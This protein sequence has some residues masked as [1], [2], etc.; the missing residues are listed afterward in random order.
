MTDIAGDLVRLAGTLLDFG[1]VE[2]AT[3]HQDGKTMETDTTHTVMLAVVACCLAE[4]YAPEL[5][6]GAIAQLALVH[7][8]PEVYAGDTQTL[9][10]LT[11]QAQQD[12]ERRELA[13]EDQL[14]REYQM[15]LWLVA[16]LRSY[17]DQSSK[18][19]RWVRAV[20][21]LLPKLTHLLNDVCV[22]LSKGMT[23]A[24][25]DLRYRRQFSEMVYAH[26]WPELMDLYENLA[27]R[28]LARAAEKEAG[29]ARH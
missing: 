3:R 27:K 6:R 16:W 13:A 22:P 26:C 15:F 25:L 17:G 18:E 24:E 8:L 2:R 1:K 9:Y 7:D 20:D 4:R 11:P 23:G 10:A 28:V 12:K 14:V 21:K 19:A 29:D 5:D